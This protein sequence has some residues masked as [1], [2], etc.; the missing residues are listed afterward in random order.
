[1]N[2]LIMLEQGI[3]EVQAFSGGKPESRLEYLAEYI[4]DFTTYEKE[5]AELFASK[6][7][8]VCAAI[9]EGR[10]FEH[11]RDNDDNRRWYLLM[12]NMPFFAKRIEWGTSIRGAWWGARPDRPITLN[13]VGLFLDGEQITELKFTN[14][15]WREFIAAVL[16]FGHEKPNAEVTG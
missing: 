9:N 11:I 2:Y 5:M 6:A 15:K 13:S 14:D 16:A 8:E 1:M 10:T 4:F 12:C 7:L 3:K